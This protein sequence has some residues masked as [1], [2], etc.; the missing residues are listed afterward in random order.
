MADVDGRAWAF[1]VDPRPVPL[2]LM[3]DHS[4]IRM[5]DASGNTGSMVANLPANTFGMS[6][7]GQPEPQRGRRSANYDFAHLMP[8]D[9]T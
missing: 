3:H 5:L 9:R 8:P 4:G 2:V 7:I 6:G 1:D